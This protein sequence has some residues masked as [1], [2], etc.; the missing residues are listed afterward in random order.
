[1]TFGTQFLNLIDDGLLGAAAIGDPIAARMAIERAIASLGGSAG[2]GGTLYLK[3]SGEGRIWIDVTQVLV[4][5][6]N[7]ELRVA[8]GVTLVLVVDRHRA[9]AF[10]ALEVA[11]P[12]HAPLGQ[13]FV[14]AQRFEA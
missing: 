13:V 7:I 5:P 11:G 14:P 3:R 10:G 2:I 1:M 4:I 9:D 6:P 8:H 12:F